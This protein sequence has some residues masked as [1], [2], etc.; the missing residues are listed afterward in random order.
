MAPVSTI[1]D[2]YCRSL[3]LLGMNKPVE[4]VPD[5]HL[6]IR[7]GQSSRPLD[8]RAPKKIFSALRASV[9]SKNKGGPAPRATPLD[10]TLRA[11]PSFVFL[12]IEEEKRRPCL[13]GAK[14]LRSALP[15][16][17]D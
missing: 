12:F 3:E 10:L 15:E 13:T 17:L 8:K 11:E 5:P 2:E 6:E 9:W 4:A 1:C 14:P 16:L 7:R